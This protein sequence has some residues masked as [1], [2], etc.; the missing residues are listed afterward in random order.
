M[1]HLG[2]WKTVRTYFRQFL[3]W[4]KRNNGS[5]STRHG[6]AVLWVFGQTTDPEVIHSVV[7]FSGF[8]PVL[9][10]NSLEPPFLSASAGPAECGSS[11]RVSVLV[12]K[13]WC[14]SVNSQAALFLIPHYCF[15]SPPYLTDPYLPPS[16]RLAPPHLSFP[17]GAFIPTAMPAG[18]AYKFIVSIS[19]PFPE[20]TLPASHKALGGRSSRKSNKLSFRRSYMHQSVTRGTLHRPLL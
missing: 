9:K 2:T 3:L 20:V 8:P 17:E 13:D 14:L 16:F 7:V 10:T 18:A 4:L 12:T 11:I 1:L 19:A 15:S 6:I 5:N